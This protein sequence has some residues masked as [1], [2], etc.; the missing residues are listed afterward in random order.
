ML[1]ECDWSQE[2][3]LGLGSQGWVVDWR[4]ESQGVVGLGWAAP[5]DR[6]DVLSDIGV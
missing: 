3:L 6:L 4:S 2:W 1:S 5:G